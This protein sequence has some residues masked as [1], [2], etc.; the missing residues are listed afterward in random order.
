VHI[1]AYFGGKNGYQRKYD[2]GVRAIIS[3]HDIAG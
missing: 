1:L 2:P 3:T